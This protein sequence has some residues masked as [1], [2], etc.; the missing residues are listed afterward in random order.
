M[1]D[2]S[3]SLALMASPPTTADE[4]PIDFAHLAR[5][6]LGDHSLQTQ[7]LELFDRQAEL[8]L[9]R[10]GEAAPAGVASL[11]HTLSGS[12]RGVGAWRVAAAAESLERAVAEAREL[13][14]AM[15][16]LAPAI[17]RL[18]AAVGEARL[19]VGATLRAPGA[20]TPP[21][22]GVPSQAAKS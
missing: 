2:L 1:T 19:A 17:E 3:K 8:L 14:A 7:V 10:M 6:T 11:A 18:V 5:M 22:A 12:A 21:R 9:V 15:E 20:A 4:P 16:Q 13:A